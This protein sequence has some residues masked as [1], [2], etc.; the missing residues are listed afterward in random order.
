MIGF[1]QSD[2]VGMEQRTLIAGFE[3]QLREVPDDSPHSKRVRKTLLEYIEEEKQYGG[4][5]DADFSFEFLEVN[6]AFQIHPDPK[7]QALDLD[8]RMEMIF[9]LEHYP[10]L[11]LKCFRGAGGQHLFFSKGLQAL[12]VRPPNPF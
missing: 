1:H 3:K 9:P 12:M 11:A 8:Y 4:S 7:T 6:L 10:S 2:K 5:R